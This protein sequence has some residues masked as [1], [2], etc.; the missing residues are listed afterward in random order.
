MDKN[1]K[2]QFSEMVR[3]YSNRVSSPRAHMEIIRDGRIIAGESCRL[4]LGTIVLCET[5]LNPLF[6]DGY[7]CAT[8]LDVL[9][10]FWL[11]Q[12]RNLDDAVYLVDNQDEL[13]RVIIKYANNFTQKDLLEITIDFSQWMENIKSSFPI[14]P[15]CDDGAVIDSRRS[16]WYIDNIDQIASEY[17]WKPEFIMWELP[18]TRNVRLRESIT[19]RLKGVQVHDD[20]RVKLDDLMGDIRSISDGEG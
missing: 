10:A 5:A 17:G 19:A 2:K 15:P 20:N 12:D 14:S 13:R 6:V 8:I 11:C 1:Y 3:E 4:T 7:T 9:E 18:W 16:D